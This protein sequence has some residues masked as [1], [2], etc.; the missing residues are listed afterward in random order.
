MIKY[1]LKKTF[2]IHDGE[3][4]IAILMQ[5]YIFIVITVLLL[6]K[7]TVSALFLSELGAKSLP[8]AFV[9]VAVVAI[10]TSVFYNKLVEKYSI[11]IIAI[12]TIILFSACFYV[13]S[14]VVYENIVTDWVLYFYYL[15]LSLFGVLVT[16]QF[17]V[18]A[19]LVFDLR[20]AKRL[21]GFIG[22]GAIA[23]GI[24]GGYLTTFLAN[25]FGNYIVIL[26]AAS[27]LLLC[28]P[29]L[30]WIW[31]V[32]VNGM[33]KY[34]Q[35]K[36]KP[37]EKKVSNNSFKLILNTKHLLN[38]ALLVGVSVLVAK[39]VDY[40]FSHFAHDKYPN[41]DDLTSFFGFW[42]STF[43]IISLVIQLFLTNRLL[44]RFN[45]SF[46]LILLPLGIAIGGILFV[47]SPLLWVII[48]MKGV[49]SSFKQSINKA[50]F[51]LS[52]LPISYEVKKTA[53]PFID[54]VVDSVA[55]GIAGF[56]L[57]F[58]IKKL[59]VN[60]SYVN[61]LILFFLAIWIYLIFRIRKSYFDSFRQNITSSLV[62]K[63]KKITLLRNEE[64]ESILEVLTSGSEKDIIYILKHLKDINYKIKK[65]Y[66]LNLFDH[67]SKEVKVLAV[68][69]SNKYNDK[70]TLSKIKDLIEN[71]TL[72]RV[73]YEAMDYLLTHSE[74]SNSEVFNFY[75][76]HKKPYLSNIALVCL[77]KASKR[78]ET[79]QSKYDIEKRIETRINEYK[80]KSIGVNIRKEDII[81]LLATIGFYGKEKY[82][83]YI[84]DNLNNEDE[85]VKT[86]AIRSA[87]LT[88]YEPFIDLLIPIIKE[89]KYKDEVIEALQGY[90]ESIVD[91]LYK[92]NEDEVFN[93]E[94]RG[95]IPKIINEFKTKKSII[96]LLNLLKNKDV[97]VRL[98]AAESLEGFKTSSH[99]IHI[100]AERLKNVFFDECEYFKNTIINIQSLVNVQKTETNK[101][102]KDNR[103][104]LIKHLKIQLD[105]SLKTIFNIL[106]IKYTES[107]MDIAFLGL[108]NDTKKSRINTLEFLNNM[109]Q[110][111]LKKE[112][113]P[114]LEYQFLD[115]EERKIEIN[116]IPENECL[117]S[118][119]NNRGVV[120]KIKVL[121]LLIS[122]K[123]KDTSIQKVVSQFTKH[124]NE[125]LRNLAIG[126]LKN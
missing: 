52:I 50:S 12:S 9:L 22:A 72:D 41:P 33:N 114:L 80:G 75:L 43:N 20:E 39:L 118:M 106:S 63:H 40:Q 117:L 56:L 113:I 26:V 97:L 67:P 68:I 77:A 10:L 119:L 25:F 66:I 15:M 89:E 104:N 93:D 21:F 87:G 84:I 91:L 71:C 102:V 101:E 78:N 42:F 4:K 94:V 5:S 11:K 32:R 120:S 60:D 31:N 3:F 64:L 90:G 2:N 34:I 95:S 125:T 59:D 108:K 30:F 112:L 35:D 65:K 14:Y 38:L 107:D 103:K 92:K 49:D 110:S 99:K 54:V 74:G 73:V 76:D 123:I 28:L 37:S 124:K 86:Y 100:R 13:L 46:N 23:G 36:R 7:P 62:K 29:L 18:I 126:Y 19:N 109:L 79:L 24:L 1:Y 69:E 16:S 83:H 8:Y 48:L 45:L 70:K 47:V 6:V 57:L 81:S 122:A 111:D 116:D 88:H 105:D 121:I 17:W 44:S 51:E 27:L 61:W 85:L 55:T 96:V 58:V 82:F 98:N 115:H 53:K